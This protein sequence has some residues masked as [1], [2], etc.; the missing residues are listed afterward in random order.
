VTKRLQLIFDLDEIRSISVVNQDRSTTR[1]GSRA[2]SRSDRVKEKRKEKAAAAR[3]R[4]P[5]L[6]GSGS[7]LSPATPRHGYQIQSGKAVKKNRSLP[8]APRLTPERYRFVEALAIAW[9]RLGT[10]GVC[11]LATARS[12]VPVDRPWIGPAHL[13]SSAWEQSATKAGSLGFCNDEESRA[14]DLAPNHTVGL[15][16]SEDASRAS[17]SLQEAIHL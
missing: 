9:L 6:T 15:W 7:I 4:A 8:R 11:P 16:S 5:A 14:L 17:A 1:R 12:F 13:A 10:E 3:T 2:G